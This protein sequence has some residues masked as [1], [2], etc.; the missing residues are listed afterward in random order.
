LGQIW[1]IPVIASVLI[2]GLIGFS[3][4]ASA[5]SPPVFELKWGTLGSGDGQFEYALDTAV[6]TAGNVY[7]A[8]QRNHRIQMFDSSGVFLTKWG[9]QGSGDSQFEFPGGIAVDSTGNVY[10]ADQSNHRI[11]K[12]DSSGAFLTK[13][14]SFGSGDGQFSSP[15][16]I[17]VDTAGN[18][19]VADGFNNRVQKFD[20]SGNF[21]LKWGSSGSG[22]GQFIEVDDVA[23]DSA[24]NV[25]TISKMKVQKFDSSGVFLATWGSFS[26][27][28]LEDGKFNFPTGIAVD[29]AG[30]VYVA[31]TGN[32]R[33]QKF[34]S[35]GAFLTKWGSFGSGDGQFSGPAGITVDSADSVYVAEAF[36]NHRVQKFLIDSDGDGITDPIDNCAFAANPLQTD[37][38]GDGIGDA[39]N[40]AEDAD[41]DEIKDSLD[42]CPLISN[43]DQADVDEDFRGDACDPFNT[44]P[45]CG[46]GTIGSNELLQCVIDPAFQTS[47]GTGTI[48]QVDDCVVDPAITLQ[49]TNLQADLTTAQDSLNDLFTNNQCSPIADS[50]PNVLIC[51]TDLND[52]IT[53][54]EAQLP[55]I[56]SAITDLGVSVISST[57]VDLSWTAPDNGVL[58][59]QGYQVFRNISAGGWQPLIAL[60]GAGVSSH[61][62]DTLSSGD[63]VIYMVRAVNAIGSATPSNIP[64]PVV[65]P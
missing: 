62:D 2:L 14:G 40:D 8:D 27:S 7:V 6:D 26:L 57:Q 3:Q 49:I 19:Y 13:W 25:Y 63:I 60:P 15:S 45:V 65:T 42:N 54:L 41:G 16:G 30:N 1:A 12:F 39:C 47:C 4:E 32:Y 58:P 9:S 43:V 37:T 34:D 61:S 59:I 46:I 10:V 44:P 29:T 33:I 53:E 18:V 22:N 48:L 50:I 23:V 38:D 55:T 28:G 20:S 64:T 56:P 24:G 36:N 5:D 17:A 11:Q 31:D 35:S 21:L 51:I 52:R